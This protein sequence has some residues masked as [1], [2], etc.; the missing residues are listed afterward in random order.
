MHEAHGCE[1]RAWLGSV[2]AACDD[3]SIMLPTHALL[4]W[5]A[6][7]ARDL[8]WRDPATSPWGVLVSEVMLQQTPV[9]RV[10][11]VYQ[12]WIVRWPDPGSLAAD[13][14][15]AAVREWG[16]LGYPRRALR[17]HDAAVHCVERHHGRLPRELADLRALPGVGEYTAA[18]VAAFAFGQRQAVLDTNV[19]RVHA[20]ALGGVAFE[21]AGGTTAAERS[22]ALTLLPADERDAA[23]LSIAVM[24]LGALVCT[25]RAPDCGSCPISNDCAWRRLGRP[26]WDGPPRRAQTYA[27]TDRQCRGRLLSVLREA[28]GPVPASAL[29]QVWDEA[30]QRERALDGLVAD[31]LVEPLS[32]GR[33]SLPG[34]RRGSRR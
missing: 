33:Y 15:A 29:A 21:P 13:P 3:R 5:Y 17:L 23:R 24:E 6:D 31:G 34:D 11:P 26:E 25:A 7:N 2:G 9:V 1:P 20:R 10:V 4:S 14:A 32:R 22:R 18:A 19:R 8:P 27:G 30:Q 16:R 28:P 12:R